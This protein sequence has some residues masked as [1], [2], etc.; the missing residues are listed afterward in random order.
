MNRGFETTRCILVVFKLSIHSAALTPQLPGLWNLL[1]LLS[2]NSQHLEN[3]FFRPETMNPFCNKSAS[4][5]PFFHGFRKQIVFFF[6]PV[7]KKV[8]PITKF[9]D[10]QVLS[11]NIF[12]PVCFKG[13]QVIVDAKWENDS[14]PL[15]NREKN[16]SESFVASRS[17]STEVF[18]SKI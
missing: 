7:M 4:I 14:F 16:V 12:L 11:C 13:C 2:P 5:W 15:E 9:I 10:Y 3:R 6:Q 8:L 17:W 1:N 18:S